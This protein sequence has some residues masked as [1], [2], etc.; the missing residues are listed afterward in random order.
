MFLTGIGFLL[1]VLALTQ[2]LWM[3]QEVADTGELDLQAYGWT[4]LIE[5]RWN[6]GVLSRTTYTPYSSPSFTDFRM[7]EVAS[8]SY[9][10][11]LA[12][13]VALFVFG[14]V[15]YVSRSRGASRSPVLVM[16]LATLGLGTGAVTYPVLAIPPAAALDID[17]LIRGFFG[18]ASAGGSVFSWGAAAGWWVWV[19]ATLLALVAVFAPLRQ[20]K[21]WARA[22]SA[23]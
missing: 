23:R 15:Q 16:G 20:E 22:S 6:A 14:G 4:V 12:F 9:A 5:E 21:S 11:G 8:N 17:P 3:F 10:I 18:T 2:P 7:R 13:V 19:A 1:G